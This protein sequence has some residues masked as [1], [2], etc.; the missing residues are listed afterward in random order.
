MTTEGTSGT[1]SFDPNTIEQTVDVETIDDNEDEPDEEFFTV[2]LSNPV[3]A[4]LIDDVGRG[5]I[6]DNDESGG[7]NTGDDGED[8][9]EKEAVQRR[10]AQANKALLP[11]IGRAM[12][13][14]A[15]RCRIDQALSGIARGAGQA[16]VSPSLSLMP[17]AGGHGAAGGGSLSLEQALG[18]ASFLL[19]LIGGESGAPQI[20]TWGCGDFRALASDVLGEMGPWGG[21]VSTMQVGFDARFSSHMLAGMALSRSQGSFDYDGASGGVL[22]GGGYDLQLTGVHPYWGM[23]LSPDIQV[24]GTVGLARGTLT[25]S[26]D[27]AGASLDSAATLLSGTVGVNGRLLVHDET[28]LRLK[29]EWAFARL[30]LGSSDAAFREASADLRRLRLAAEAEHWWLIPRVGCSRRGESWAYATTA[31]MERP[32]PARRSPPVCATA[33]SSRAGT[34]RSLVAGARRR[35]RCRRNAGSPRVSATIRRCSASAPG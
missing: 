15:V 24:W 11:E 9:T 28:T 12:A 32:A 20:A 33:T 22:S 19:P 30:D 18:G 14:T 25:A 5:G 31:A 27:R 1:L 21:D 8:R 10:I 7:M 35:T 2:T 17:V 4:T 23:A 6:T 16:S 34:R 29:G 3:G 26:D 13:F